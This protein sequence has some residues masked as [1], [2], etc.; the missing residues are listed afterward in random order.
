MVWNVLKK[1]YTGT[2]FNELLIG[3]AK[4]P[5]E[6]DVFETLVFLSERIEVISWE[7][8]DKSNQ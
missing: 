6:N 3:N 1:V 7:V 5:H 4:P 8:I 2:K